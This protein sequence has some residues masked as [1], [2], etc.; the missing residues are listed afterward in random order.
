MWVSFKERKPRENKFVITRGIDGEAGERF[1]KW[2]SWNDLF[3]KLKPPVTHWW[4]G[5]SDIEIATKMWNKYGTKY[6]R[7]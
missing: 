1:E 4:D 3:L 7:E 5:D 2:N 6:K